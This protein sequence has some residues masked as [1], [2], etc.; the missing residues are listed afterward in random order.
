LSL[1]RLFDTTMATIPGQVP[2]LAA[3]PV[4]VAAGRARLPARQ[5]LRV[6]LSWSGNADHVNDRQRSMP[7][8]ALAPLVGLDG[9]SLVSLQKDKRTGDDEFLRA[10]PQIADVAADLHSYADTAALIVNLD[11]VI[12]VD[13][14]VAHLAG[15]LARPLFVML[16]FASDWRWFDRRFDS[17]WYPTARLYRQPRRA[18][19]AAVISDVREAIAAMTARLPARRWNRRAVR[20][21]KGCT[22][23]QRLRGDPNGQGRDPLPLHRPLCFHRH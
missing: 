21:L 2:Y 17:P 16:P 9:V 10:H 11:L 1:P 5:R 23:V 12:A 19:W 22:P 14:S 13:T 4:K 3:D 8:Q 20:R 15:A 6:G 7:P 18:D